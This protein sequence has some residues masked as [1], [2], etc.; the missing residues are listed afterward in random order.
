MLMHVQD[1]DRPQAL[2][3]AG[4]SVR[5]DRVRALDDVSFAVPLGGITGL[6]GRNGAGKS[7]SIRVLAG[8][9]PPDEAAV[10]EVLG[11]AVADNGREARAE[12]G[13]LLA[14]PA[15]FP[16]L[17]PRET[18]RFLAEAYGLAPD[19]AAARAEELIAY[20][21]LD[22]AADRLVEGF[23]TG[24]TKRLALAAALVHAPRL[25]I[26]DEPFESLD[27]LMVRALKQLLTRYVAGGG[28]VLLSSHLLDAVEEICD[29]IVIVEQGRVV[30]DAPKATARARAEAELG[31]GSLEELYA[32]V[33]ATEQRPELAWVVG[34]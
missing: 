16:Y 28:S 3:L 10:V 22:E 33:V 9:L 30:A 11:H 31:S 5:F 2:R 24:M 26:L 25:L 14:E 13:Y 32:S 18:L 4:V 15:L 23:S 29:H 17:T 27:P 6:V 8:L 19:V 1:D 34:G 7:T 21:G 12:T 20:F